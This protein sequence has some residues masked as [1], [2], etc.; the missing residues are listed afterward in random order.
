MFSTTTI[1]SSTR[2]PIA[3]TSANRV[4]RFRVYPSRRYTSRVRA[5]VTGTATS[6]TTAS[7][8]PSASQTSK[9]TPSV[10]MRR[11][12]SSSIAFSLAVSP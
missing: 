11:W 8:Q 10:A 4:I 7:R 9:A 3:K 5:S 1:A 2:M 12:L 6:T